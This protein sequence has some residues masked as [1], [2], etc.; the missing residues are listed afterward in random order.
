MEPRRLVGLAFTVLALTLAL[1]LMIASGAASATTASA[2][3][4][5]ASV[6]PEMVL[7]ALTAASGS[8]KAIPGNEGSFVMS[9]QRPSSQVTWFT[10]RPMRDSGFIPTVEFTKGW[11]STN[12]VTDPPNVALV[13]RSPSGRTDTLVAVMSR[14][15]VSASGAFT[16]HL[17]LLSAQEAQALKG[18]LARHAARSLATVPARFTAAAL[19]IDDM[20]GHMVIADIKG[21]MGDGNEG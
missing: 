10:D 8:L 13:M 18:S 21:Q 14:P 2:P 4:V 20:K 7:Y 16:A 1:P 3:S 19:F 6:K 17:R 15:A 9:L 12:F 5:I 11:K